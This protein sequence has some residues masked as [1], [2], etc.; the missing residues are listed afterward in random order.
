MDSRRGFTLIELLVVIGIIGIL[1]GLLL[2]AVQKVREAARRSQCS[3]NLHQIGLALQ[4]HH[5]AKRAF[6]AGNYAT[7]AGV[8]PGGSFVG[9]TSESENRANWMIL[10]LPFLNGGQLSEEYDFRKHNEAPENRI[11]RE[12]RVSTYSC[13]SDVALELIV[14]AM[15][16]AAEYAL[17]VPYMPGS[18]RAV[19]GR[20][21]GYRFLD[22]GEKSASYP[23]RWRGAMHTVGV[24]NFAPERMGNITDGESHTLMVGEAATR[25]N[26]PYRTLWAYSFS[27]YSLSATTPQRRTLLGDFDQC[28]AIGGEGKSGPCRRGWGSPHNGGL[29]FL[30]CDGSVQFLSQDIDMELFAELGTIAG[31]EQ[32]Q[33]PR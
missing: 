30:L 22:S 21:D 15:G 2:P 1:I 6:P 20:S 19:S 28:K 3:N 7:T 13:P 27:F 9:N 29:N 18:Y 10:I 17:N 4:N 33:V 24:S 25:S 16:P 12:T 26:L 14:P 31:G 5:G 32:V 11:V 8:C 23:R